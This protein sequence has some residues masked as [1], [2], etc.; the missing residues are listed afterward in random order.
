VSL[1]IIE[2]KCHQKPHLL[3]LISR[4][5]TSVSLQ[6]N[7]PISTSGTKFIPVNDF[8]FEYS[9]GIIKGEMLAFCSIGFQK[10]GNPDFNLQERG[11]E[12]QGGLLPQTP[13]GI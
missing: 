13:A 1:E 8:P 2:M 6:L 11:K 3:F 12:E 10:D 9:K 7:E 4:D 5:A